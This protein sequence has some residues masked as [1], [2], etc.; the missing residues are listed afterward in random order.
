[1]CVQGTGCGTPGHVVKVS[2]CRPDLINWRIDHASVVATQQT[3]PETSVN[4]I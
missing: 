4:L 2:E 1:M 3:P